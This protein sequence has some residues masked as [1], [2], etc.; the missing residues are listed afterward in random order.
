MRHIISFICD[1]FVIG[2]EYFASKKLGI[3]TPDGALTCN[4]AFHST[5]C[6]YP[7]IWPHDY[8]L[9]EI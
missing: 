9:N 1:D 8:E 2:E 4:L 7:S 6:V 3:G 5:L